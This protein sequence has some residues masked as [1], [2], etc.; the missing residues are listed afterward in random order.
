MKER[1]R[2]EYSRFIS[3]LMC[4]QGVKEAGRD[5]VI[6]AIKMVESGGFAPVLH[7]FEDPDKFKRLSIDSN[8]DIEVYY[9]QPIQVKRWDCPIIEPIKPPDETK[10][11][12]FCA[13]PRKGGNG[14]TL[15]DEAIRG[16]QD[17]G[18]KVQKFML[19]KMKIGS[20]LGCKE[21]RQQGF[22]GF[23]LL[24]DD[25]TDIYPKI[26]DSD[27][28]IFDFPIYT[29]RE[30]GQLA[31][32]LDRWYPLGAYRLKTS[33]RAMVISTWGYPYVDTYDYL[34]DRIILSLL[35]F[36]MVTVE[37]LSACGFAGMLNGL[38]DKGKA[39]ILRFPREVEKAYQAGKSLVTGQ[40]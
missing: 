29:G 39:M 38:D 28:V 18:A 35:S 40:R 13:S 32:F 20:C 34:I 6:E 7:R 9:A 2:E 24:K 5:L 25:M 10:V 26:V 22:E 15:I 36:N 23:C 3:F 30:C 37:S 4:E 27:A 8:N 17:A 11:L 14:D 16:A 1:R 21:C 31:I 12:A 19:Q 33:R